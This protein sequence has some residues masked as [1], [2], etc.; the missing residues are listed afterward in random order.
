MKDSAEVTEPH[1][2]P[3]PYVLVVDDDP[4]M[5]RMAELTLLG[6][7]YRT[8]V[9]CHPS[10]AL[11]HLKNERP[12]VTLLDVVMPEMDGF[13]LLAQMQSY[14]IAPSSV[15]M[16][17]GLASKDDMEQA[18]AAGIYSYLKKPFTRQ[19]MLFAISECLGMNRQ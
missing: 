2:D 16:M 5:A 18:R 3:V 8:Q 17:S 7:G 15:I 11:D 6:H 14:G 10:Q 19:D 12:D 1:P 9:A 4:H 13:E